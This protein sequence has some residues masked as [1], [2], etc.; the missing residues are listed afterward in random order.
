MLKFTPIM[1]AFCSSLLPSYY[2]NNFARKIDPSLE[3][4]NFET[5]SVNAAGKLKACHLHMH[6]YLM[7]VAIH[8]YPAL[9]WTQDILYNKISRMKFR[10]RKCQVD[11][12]NH[13]NYIPRVYSYMHGLDLVSLYT[14]GQQNTRVYRSHNYSTTC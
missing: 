10:G 13:E 6:V 2:P 7:Y 1:P 12:E 14:L 5:R 4:N 3:V 9:Q 8:T 11:C